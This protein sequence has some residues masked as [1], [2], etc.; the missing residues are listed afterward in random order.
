VQRL[1]VDIDITFVNQLSRAQQTDEINNIRRWIQESM[2][3]AQLNPQA[4]DYVN[5]DAIIKFIAKT[6]GVPE[7]AVMNDK[8]VQALREERAKAQ[9]AQLALQSA[10]VLGDVAA[11]TGVVNEP[12]TTK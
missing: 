10:Q 5:A 8:D 2:E 9:Q 12:P 7:S 6:R 1:G 11:K 4:L 3:L